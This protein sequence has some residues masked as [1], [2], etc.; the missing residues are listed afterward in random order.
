MARLKK[1]DENTTIDGDG[2]DQPAIDL[3]IPRTWFCTDEEAEKA[4]LSGGTVPTLGRQCALCPPEDR[5]T[6]MTGVVSDIDGKELSGRDGSPVESSSRAMWVLIGLHQ[7][8]VHP[9]PAG[10]KKKPFQWLVEVMAEFD[11]LSADGTLVI[12]GTD[13]GADVIYDVGARQTSGSRTARFG[14]KSEPQP[15]ERTHSFDCSYQPLDEELI[16]YQARN[17]DLFD[18]YNGRTKE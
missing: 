14:V 15:Q 6:V 2:V 13:S 18:R 17:S 11:R 8:S 9:V 5:Y 12:R 3:T 10:S 7:L 4:I 16:A 1:T